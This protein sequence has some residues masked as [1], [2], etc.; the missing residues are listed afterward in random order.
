MIV[1]INKC[2]EKS[3]KGKRLCPHGKH[4]KLWEHE[5]KRKGWMRNKYLVYISPKVKNKKKTTK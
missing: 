4:M 2:Q 5:S 1:E 3:C